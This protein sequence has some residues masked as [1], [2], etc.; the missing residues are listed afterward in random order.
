MGQ[1]E[2]PSV[3]EAATPLDEKVI[4]FF[5]ELAGAAP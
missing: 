2:N 4:A 3:T 1:L 5:T